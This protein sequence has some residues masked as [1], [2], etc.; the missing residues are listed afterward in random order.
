MAEGVC[1]DLVGVV[2][3]CD[4]VGVD[5]ERFGVDFEAGEGD[6]PA[7]E[8][9]L[10][11]RCKIFEIMLGIPGVMERFFCR[12]KVALLFCCL[13]VLQYNE[14]SRYLCIDFHCMTQT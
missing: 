5:R 3:D 10:L 12:R 14:V 4:G 11:L 9:D 1:L 13:F 6:V 8:D 2:G 7:D